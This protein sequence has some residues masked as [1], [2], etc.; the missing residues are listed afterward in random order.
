VK[1]LVFFML[2]P[3]VLL[4]VAWVFTQFETTRH[5]QALPVDTNYST[6]IVLLFPLCAMLF[7]FVVLWR[8]THKRKK[9]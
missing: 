5:G 6:L 9:P 1:N 3:P 4:T 8:A 2:V 7:L